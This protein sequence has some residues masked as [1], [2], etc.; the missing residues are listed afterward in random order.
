MPGSA[1]FIPINGRACEGTAPDDEWRGRALILRAQRQALL[2]S[3]IANADTPGYQAKDLNFSGAMQDAMKRL[4][5]PTLQTTSAKHATTSAL[6]SETLSTLDFA[7][8][9][10]PSQASMDSN[11]V[12]MDRER[13]EFSKNAILHRLA[14]DTF[15]DEYK[16]FKLAASDPRR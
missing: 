9:V 1:V 3:N 8:Y 12:D 2:A 6:S 14:I 4:P 16:E 7:R 10:V 5:G 13:A 15:S 11:T